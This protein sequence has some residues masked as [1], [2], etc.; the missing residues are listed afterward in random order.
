MAIMVNLKRK[1]REIVT[2][3]RLV[4]MKFKIFPK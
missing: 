2:I 3:K 1:K 4:L